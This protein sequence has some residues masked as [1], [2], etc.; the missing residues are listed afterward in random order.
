MSREFSKMLANVC[1]LYF[2]AVMAYFFFWQV[3]SGIS[4]LNIIW[5]APYT[6][7]TTLFLVPP[8]FSM[9]FNGKIFASLFTAVLWLASIMIGDFLLIIQR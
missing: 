4:W 3:P 5:V 7:F 1:A 9:F 6:F 8:S 2:L